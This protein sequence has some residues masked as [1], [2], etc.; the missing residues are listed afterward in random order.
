MCRVCCG[1]GSITV[2]VWV[3]VSKTETETETE[4]VPETETEPEGP[5]REAGWR[6]QRVATLGSRRARP[7]R[8]VDG[9]WLS[10]LWNRARGSGFLHVRPVAGAAPARRAPVNLMVSFTL[11]EPG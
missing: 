1:F 7:S 8:R 10:R 4:P 6:R 2:P 3:P 11:V 5:E 9:G